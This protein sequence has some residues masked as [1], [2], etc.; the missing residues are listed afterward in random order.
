MPRSSRSE[1]KVGDDVRIWVRD[2]ESIREFAARLSATIVRARIDRKTLAETIGIPASIIG[3]LAGGRF[4]VVTLEA[5][6]ALWAWCETVGVSPSW[7]F[8]GVEQAELPTLAEMIVRE[9]APKLTSQLL[10]EIIG[11]ITPEKEEHAM[12][13]ALRAPPVGPVAAIRP[14]PAALTPPGKPK[15]HRGYSTIAAEDLPGGQWWRD[16]VP[17][18]GRVAGGQGNP[19]VEPSEYPPSWAG[20]YVRYHGAPRTAVAVRVAGDSMAPDYADGDMVIV[21]PA[22]NVQDGLC[23][24]ILSSDGL[25]DV[26]LKKLAVRG[27]QAFLASVNRAYRTVE[28][29]ASELVAAFPVIGHLPFLEE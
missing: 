24:V 13:Q 3:K 25:R 29:A 27:A 6:Q 9:L 26:R 2:P 23:C 28:V 18:L 4:K 12:G 16:F 17:V 8:R 19:L 10:L 21:D 7:L 20:E 14:V 22:R 1:P 15:P 11:K 5:V